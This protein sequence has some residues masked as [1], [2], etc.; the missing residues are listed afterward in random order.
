VWLPDKTVSEAW[1]DY[2]KTGATSDT[3]P[4][5]APKRVRVSATGE[6]T[7]GADADFESGLAGFLIERD[8]DNPI[9][10]PVT[11]QR[12]MPAYPPTQTA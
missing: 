10:A 6:L 9:I 3:T 7:W 11:N 1:G 5:P 12:P 2:V 4:P 8:G